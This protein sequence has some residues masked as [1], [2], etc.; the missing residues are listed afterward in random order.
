MSLVIHTPGIKETK[1]EEPVFDEKRCT[2][3]V[4]RCPNGKIRGRST[5]SIYVITRLNIDG[6]NTTSDVIGFS[7]ED[8][9]GSQFVEMIAAK[10]LYGRDWN[11]SNGS[12]CFDPFREDG[13]ERPL[14]THKFMMWDEIEQDYDGVV[15]MVSR[16]LTIYGEKE[17]G[18]EDRRAIKRYLVSQA[19]LCLLDYI[20]METDGDRKFI[21]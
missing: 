4:K 2:D 9:F 19:Q 3:V 15:S 20:A 1:V 21:Q 6:E 12:P 10:E 16:S 7:Y 11:Y 14:P 8:K 17:E 18:R 13:T 5:A